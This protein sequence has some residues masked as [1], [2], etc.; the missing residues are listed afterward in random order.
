MKVAKAKRREYSV[1]AVSLPCGEC[2]EGG[3]WR[4][5][6]PDGR[7]IHLNFYKEEGAAICAEELNLALAAGRKR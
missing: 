3:V 1:V 5:A 4:V 2:E 6:T 7:Q